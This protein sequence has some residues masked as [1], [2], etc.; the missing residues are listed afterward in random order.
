MAAIE[1]TRPAPFGAISAFR[2]VSAVERAVE[3]FR[4]YWVAIQTRDQLARLSPRQLADIG[5]ADATY[6]RLDLDEI[7]RVLAANR[8]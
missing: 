1:T 5:L 8:R 2:F 4:A 6:S 7:A 3:A